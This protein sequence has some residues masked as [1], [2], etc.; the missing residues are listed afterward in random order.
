MRRQSRGAVVPVCQVARVA[1]D[2]HT[3]SAL[4]YSEKSMLRHIPQFIT[5]NAINLSA[6]YPKNEIMTSKRMRYRHFPMEKRFDCQESAGC[7]FRTIPSCLSSQKNDS[8]D[9]S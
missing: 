1:V 5:F 4:S 8:R 2:S 7:Q 9:I 6:M 3:T